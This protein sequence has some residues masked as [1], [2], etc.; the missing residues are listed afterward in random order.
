MEGRVSDFQLLPPR[1]AGFRTGV[2]LSLAIHAGVGLTYVFRHPVATERQDP[3]DQMVVFLVPPSDAGSR[4]AHGKSIDWSALAGDGGAVQDEITAK[5]EVPEQT[6]ELGSAGDTDTATAVPDPAP[7]PEVALTEI[8]VDSAV[9]RDPTSAAPVYPEALL[10]K[11][12]EGAT[13]VHYV[14]DTTG[15]VDTSTI[16]VVRTSHPDFAASVRSALGL[17]KFRPAV[18]GTRRVRQWVEQNFAFRIVP[19]IPADTT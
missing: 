18:Q 19:R 5:A 10:K 4:A 12:V 8:E 3:I 7:A 11:S 14:V 16:E 6:L 2:L 9:V 1:A 13:F 15:R 17:M